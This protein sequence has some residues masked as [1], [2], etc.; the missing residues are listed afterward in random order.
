[1]SEQEH[2][3]E[4]ISGIYNFCDRWCEKCSYTNKCLVFKKEI[5]RNINHIL[6]DEDPNDPEVFAKDLADTFQETFDLINKK[7]N[8]DDLTDFVEEENFGLDEDNEFEIDGTE[9]PSIG[10]RDIPDPII[11]MTKKLFE[12]FLEYHALIKSKYPDNI[13]EIDN[14]LEANLSDLSWYTPQIHVKSR[15]CVWGRSKLLNSKNEFQRKI[16][17]DIL[18]V[19][20][21]I[22]FT[23]IEKCI[24][25]LKS[26]YE[27]QYEMQSKTLLLLG[28]AKQIKEMFISVF[29]NVL[30]YKRPYFD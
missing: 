4:N 17:E 20:S 26:L 13:D 15:M 7:M 24:D 29:P 16:D 5:E 21:R 6:R 22:A 19:N 25:A 1:M 3:D 10:V 18:N 14:S 12:D 27:N 9:R 23:G 8:D 30:T 2:M 28:I 11:D